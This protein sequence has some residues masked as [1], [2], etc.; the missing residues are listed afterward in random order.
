VEKM[1]WGFTEISWYITFLL[2]LLGLI[3]IL[4]KT[5]DRKYILY[6]VMGSIFGFCADIISFTSGF[7][8]YP[9]FYLITILGLPF[10]MT[11][12]EGFATAI[13]VYIAENIMLR[14]KIK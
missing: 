3:A 4:I 6:T 12:A 13:T 9:D 10:S 7:Y 2:L 5:K 1:S 11:L 8:S 14:L